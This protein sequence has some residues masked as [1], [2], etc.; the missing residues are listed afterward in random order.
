ME[1]NFGKEKVL[2][3]HDLISL[4]VFFSQTCSNTMTKTES[5]RRT[6]TRVKVNLMLEVEVERIMQSYRSSV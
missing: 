2:L 3:P 1:E 4:C 5:I 6:I